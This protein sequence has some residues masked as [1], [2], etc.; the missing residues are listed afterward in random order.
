MAIRPLAAA[1]RLMLSRRRLL[2]GLAASA[3]AAAV[4]RHGHAQSPPALSDVPDAAQA[5]MAAAALAFLGPL[6]AA[7]RKRAVCAVSDK[8]RLS[9]HYMPRRREGVAFKDMPAPARTAAHELMK[10]SR[11][12]ALRTHY[13]QGSH[14]GGHH[15]A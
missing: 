15:H 10:V 9:W 12:D 7:A 6:P 13:D 14:D 8:E 2:H 1:P 11:R 3:A 4:P 5:A